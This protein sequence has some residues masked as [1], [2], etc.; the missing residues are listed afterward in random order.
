MEWFPWFLSQSVYCWYI[1]KLLISVHSFCVL[2]YILFLLIYFIMG[3]YF[4]CVVLVE[5]CFITYVVIYFGKSSMDAKKNVY[6][7]AIRWNTLQM[8]FKSISFMVLFSCRISL[9]IF[10]LDVLSIEE[11]GVLGL[12]TIILSAP[13][14]S[15]KL[16]SICFMNLGAL[17]F[18]A[19]IFRIVTSSCWIVP[20]ITM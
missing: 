17:M 18:S 19:Y 16:K 1:E 13:I 11:I 8:S 20:F 10:Y 9:L 14:C 2:L 7:A 3:G 4:N 12:P 15:F 6:S 5:V